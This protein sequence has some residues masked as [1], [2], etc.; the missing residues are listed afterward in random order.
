MEFSKQNKQVVMLYTATLSGVLLGMLSSIVNTRFLAP[1]DY[2]DV[3]Y[4]QNI[5]NFLSAFLLFGYFLSGARLMAIST[6]KNYT[7]RIKG[8]MVII[9]A[10]ACTALILA[11]PICYYLH[12]DKPTVAILFLVS[13]PVCIYPLLYNYIEQTA[14]GDN[15]IGRLSLA[16]LLPF[17]V[18]V[19]MAYI[20]YSH[21]G[22]TSIFMILLQWGLYS[23][24][25]ICIIISTKPIFK[26]VKNAWDILHEENKRYGIQLYMGSLVMVTTNYLAGI[27]LGLFNSDNSEVGFYTLALTITSPLS[28]LPAIIGTTLF[29]KFAS[30]P[31]IP[32]KII[33][34]TVL[35]TSATWLLF[36]LLIN[37]IVGILYTERY[38]IVGIYASFLSVGCCIHGIGDMF[39]KYM[40]S[41]GQG[42]SIRNASIANGVFKIIGYI[43]LVAAFN[44]N[45]AIATTIACDIIYFMCLIY[46]YIVFIKKTAHGQI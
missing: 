41:H 38:A 1:S 22:T 19:P 3:R 13:M 27:T 11:M 25:Y 40:C 20:L 44:T 30:Q 37:T 7:Q 17:L 26:N 45:G 31:C 9:L 21:Y 16:R 36:L 24:I 46:Y 2:G 34:S 15:Q 29:K 5:I 42:V 43:V 33:V 39:N 23:L 18:Y 8:M 6:N 12:V 4:V 28:T 10:M 32:T 35:I 14:Q